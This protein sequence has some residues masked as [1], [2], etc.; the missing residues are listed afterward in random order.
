MFIILA[1]KLILYILAY[2]Q[3]LAR[4]N[5]SAPLDN[6]VLA[7]CY[8]AKPFISALWKDWE[9]CNK[10]KQSFIFL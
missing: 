5:Q 7:E 4:A 6:F 3:K 9:N 1:I 2:L 10:M 8:W